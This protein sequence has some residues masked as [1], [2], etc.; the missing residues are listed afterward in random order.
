MVV[1]IPVVSLLASSVNDFFARVAAGGSVALALWLVWMS[2]EFVYCRT[3]FDMDTGS[4][5][6]SKPYGGGEYS[7]VEL[8]DVDEV[9]IIRFGTTSFVKFGYSGPFSS[10]TP[11][12]VIDSSDTSVFVSHL[13]RH[14]IDVSS[15]SVDLWS[16]PAG[17]IHLRVLTAP[18]VLVGIPI[19]VWVLHGVDPFESSVVTAPLAVLIGASIYG[20]MKRERT[21]PP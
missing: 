14:D 18:V 12:V 16:T 11:A 3:A 7:A 1:G 8:D 13:E 2:H 21:V 4:F 10:N 15:R 6:K 17:R 5:A 20:M 19:V 9:T